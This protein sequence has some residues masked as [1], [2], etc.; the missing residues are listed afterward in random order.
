MFGVI[1][2]PSAI[3]KKNNSPCQPPKLKEAMAGPGQSPDNPQ[4]PPNMMEP[5]ISDFES[6]C[7]GFFGNKFA[8]AGFLNF[9]VNWNENLFLERFKCFLT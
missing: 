7:S 4:P 5:V 6:F 9:F 3:V 8:K 1:I 2:I